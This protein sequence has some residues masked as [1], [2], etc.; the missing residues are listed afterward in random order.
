MRPKQSFNFHSSENSL[1]ENCGAHFISNEGYFAIIF[2]T[3]AVHAFCRID[4][5][6]PLEVNKLTDFVF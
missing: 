4:S 5:G 1:F 6:E 2:G 3:Y